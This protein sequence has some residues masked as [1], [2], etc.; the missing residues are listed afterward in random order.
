MRQILSYWLGQ[1]AGDGGYKAV[2]RKFDAENW[3]CKVE[4][5]H[6]VGNLND[7]IEKAG[8]ACQR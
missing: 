2:K 8:A 3:G 4:T 7:L 1:E 6:A 5:D